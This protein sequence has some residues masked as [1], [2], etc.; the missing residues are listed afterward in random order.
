MGVSGCGKSTIGSLLGQ[1]MGWRFLDADDLH[2]A[3]NIAKM[4]RGVAL[5]DADRWPW[6]DLVASWIGERARAGQPGV[7]GCSAL[8]RS[9]RDALRQAEENL[10]LVYLTGDRD[11]LAERLARRHGHFFPQ[12]LLDAQL[13]DLEEPAP[14]EHAIVV[15]I[16]QSSP[17]ETV[18]TI[19]TELGHPRA[20]RPRATSGQAH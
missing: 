17:R 7:I 6:L 12:Q 1:R 18:D 5:T 20:A 16:G 10:R 19:A 14:D 2:P 3:E 9:Y 4:Q 13:G 11:T 15:V 8:K